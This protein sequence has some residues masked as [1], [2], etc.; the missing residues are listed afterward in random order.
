MALAHAY[1]RALVSSNEKSNGVT[2]KCQGRNR[3]LEIFVRRRAGAPIRRNRRDLR[4]Q[5][6]ERAQDHRHRLAT[7]A[8]RAINKKQSVRCRPEKPWPPLSAAETRGGG[9]SPERREKPQTEINFFLPPGNQ[10]VKKT[11]VSAFPRSPLGQPGAIRP[12]SV[13]NAE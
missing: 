10:T 3:R 4:R 2:G 11:R 9:H 7:H 13:L 8:A 1:L 6:R 12:N 5:L